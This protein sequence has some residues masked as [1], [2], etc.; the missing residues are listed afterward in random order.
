MFC[1]TVYGGNTEVAFLKVPVGARAVGMG[2]AFITIGEGVSAM[3][4]NPAGLAKI[5]SSEIFITHMELYIDNWLDFIGY[6]FPT[7]RG[8]LGISGLYLFQGE[9]KARNSN[10]EDL[11]NF[12][13]SDLAVTVSFAKNLNKIN[14]AGGNL[15]LIQ[16]RL[17]DESA[18]GL[19]MDIGGTFLT[20]ISPLT[21]SVV[22]QNMGPK[23]K[24]LEKSF[25]LPITL[26]F[27]ALYRTNRWLFLASDINYLPIESNFTISFGSEFIIS[28]ILSLRA[29]YL[30]SVTHAKNASSFG[31]GQEN[32]LD[33]LSNFSSG[34]GLKIYRYQLD[35]AFLPFGE[36][37]TSHQFSLTAR[38]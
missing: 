38:F 27:G 34:L 22:L 16:K 7:R 31:S 6:G 35:Y 23:M 29:G 20:P 36:L 4:W 9:I 24:F 26:K 17:G 33:S 10:R 14:Q 11:G 19:A 28:Q 1:S 30:S 3:L 15:K 18:V 2:Q 37:G 8:I 25:S 12:S 13:T 21:V 32:G 5:Q